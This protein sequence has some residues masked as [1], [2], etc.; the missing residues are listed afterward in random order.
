MEH[1]NADNDLVLLETLDKECLELYKKIEPHIYAG[2]NTGTKHWTW[3]TMAQIEFILL[4]DNEITFWKGNGRNGPFPTPHRDLMRK[5]DKAIDYFDD[6]EYEYVSFYD[7]VVKTSPNEMEI[8]SI[9]QDLTRVKQIFQFYAKCI[10]QRQ[11]METFVQRVSNDPKARYYP[12]M[13]IVLEPKVDSVPFKTPIMLKTDDPKSC[14]EFAQKLSQVYEV[15][16]FGLG[17]PDTTTGEYW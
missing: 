17:R 7:S 16:E 15:R 11:L 10:D 4:K 5:Y 8:D 3:I 6:H 2:P 14:D 12:G 9:C 1:K 13:T